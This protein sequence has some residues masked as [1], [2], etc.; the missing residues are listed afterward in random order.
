[1]VTLLLALTDRLPAVM[2]S[3]WPKPKSCC[4]GCINPTNALTTPASSASAAPRR[5]FFKGTPGSGFDA[6]ENLRDAM[7]C[8]EEAER[9]RSAGNDD[10]LLRWN[11]CRA[12]HHE[13]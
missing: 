7:A 3:A 13:E 12:S 6:Y 5:I 10:A 8:Y 4:P 11:A 2:P 9:L 1:L